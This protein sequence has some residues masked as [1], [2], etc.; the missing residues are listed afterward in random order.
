MSDHIE[1]GSIGSPERNEIRRTVVGQ[2]VSA[3]NVIWIR[4]T[5]TPDGDAYFAVLEVDADTARTLTP[6]DATAYARTLLRAIT[7]AEYDAAV[8]KQ[9]R[10]LDVD[11]AGSAG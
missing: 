6:D 1:Y 3:D 9:M 5:P 7:Y 8:Y 11:H 2:P 10:N 4:T